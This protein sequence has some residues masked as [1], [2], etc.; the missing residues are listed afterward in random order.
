V[1]S[2]TFV[3]NVALTGSFL[4]LF[5]QYG[6]WKPQTADEWNSILHLATRWEFDDV[7]ALA[8]REIQRQP[9]TSVEV[10]CLSREFDIQSQWTLK[11]YTQLCERPQALTLQEASALGLQTAVLI[12]QL[13]ERLR[14]PLGRRYS[15][16]GSTNSGWNRRQG[17]ST[18]PAG[19]RTGKESVAESGRATM[20]GPRAR[21]LSYSA[22]LVAETFGLVYCTGD[23]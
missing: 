23:V 12:A 11:A 1:R 20:S 4:F 10:V 8:I 2:R 13:R 22:R 6:V 9:L 5:S 19:L 3:V 16:A 15:S 21:G 14:R 7:R 17:L 18:S